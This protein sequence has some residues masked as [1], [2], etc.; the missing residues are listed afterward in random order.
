MLRA[1]VSW[2]WNLFKC[3]SLSRRHWDIYRGQ[4]LN[5]QRDT[6]LNGTERK[7]KPQN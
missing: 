2:S 4:R 3:E 1:Y 6:A 7:N 5:L